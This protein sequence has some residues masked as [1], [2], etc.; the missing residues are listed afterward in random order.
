MIRTELTA[1]CTRMHHCVPMRV[2]LV[3]KKQ[4]ILSA[5]KFHEISFI[6]QKGE[7]VNF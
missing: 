3:A 6:N 4:E 2:T 5:V 7:P 1:K